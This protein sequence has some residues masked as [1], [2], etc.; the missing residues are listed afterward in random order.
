MKI[1]CCKKYAKVA[2]IKQ[3]LNESGHNDNKYETIYVVAGSNDC[4]QSSSTP[5]SIAQE[6]QEIADVAF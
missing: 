4:K 6:T 3:S 5:E 2:N 1:V